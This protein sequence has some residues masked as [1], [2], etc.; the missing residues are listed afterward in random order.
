MEDE[1][2]DFGSS[3]DPGIS[4][5]AGYSN[6]THPMPTPPTGPMAVEGGSS[7]R[8]ATMDFSPAAQAL[9]SRAVPIFLSIFHPPAGK[10]APLSSTHF[11]RTAA[12][13]LILLP[14]AGDEQLAALAAVQEAHVADCII[15]SAVLSST[16]KALGVETTTSLG[17]PVTPF[18]G[19]PGIGKISWPDRPGDPTLG[20]LPA[21]TVPTFSPFD[22]GVDLLQPTKT[23]PAPAAPVLQGAAQPPSSGDLLGASSAAPLDVAPSMALAGGV[24]SADL[25]LF[26]LSTSSVSTPSGDQPQS[27]APPTHDLTSEIFK[28]LGISNSDGGDKG[29]GVSRPQL[30]PHEEDKTALK[31]LGKHLSARAVELLKQ[32]PDLSFMTSPTLV[33]PP[34][35]EEQL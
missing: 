14:Q 22:S 8:A 28:S 34:L 27:P 31:S 32:L 30:A 16:L 15:P 11:D 12:L 23:A 4:S 18:G 10:V 24:S 7:V 17:K 29:A 21:A 35:A 2:G 3:S 13:D 1:F 25:D 9:T 26:G 19:P 5:G 6:G 33:T 20:S